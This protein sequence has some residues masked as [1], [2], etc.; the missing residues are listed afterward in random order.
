MMGRGKSVALTTQD[1]CSLDLLVEAQWI[2]LLLVFL[3][4]HGTTSSM[5]SFLRS[6]AAELLLPPTQLARRTTPR[7]V[8]TTVGHSILLLQVKDHTL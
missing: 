3:L 1:C 5:T 6:T 4:T 7:D 2:A 8:L